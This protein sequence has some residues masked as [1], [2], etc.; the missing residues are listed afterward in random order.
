MSYQ[1]VLA[2]VA[3][4]LGGLALFAGIVAGTSYIG[5]VMNS[6]SLYQLAAILTISI[7]FLGAIGRVLGG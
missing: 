3:S 1:W 7:S 6:L 4:L 5:G 2:G